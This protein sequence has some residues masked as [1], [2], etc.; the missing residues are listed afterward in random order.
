VQEC[1]TFLNL[2]AHAAKPRFTGITHVLDSG[3]TP[4]A[5]DS[6][7]VQAGHL[8]DIVKVGWG[9]GYVDPTMPER[10]R[11]YSKHGC[12]VSL[13]GTLLEVAALQDKVG[14]LRDWALS[15]GISHVEVSNGLCA[16]TD[17][18]KHA[19]VRELA[20]DFAVLAETGSKD[21]NYPPTPGEWADEM[22]RDLEA[23]A[24]WVVAEGR[25]SGTV[26]LYD[27]DHVVRDDLVKAILTWIPQDR[28]IFEA[29]VKSQQ[30][31]FIRQLGPDV[32]VGNVAPASVLP[33]ETLRLGLR[34]DTI[35]VDVLR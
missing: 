2:P 30:A 18:R 34:A 3:L 24:T 11:I 5:T 35:S 4:L 1:P 33:L 23:G 8:V 9:I 19:L 21:G 28:V 26:G 31:W 10:V 20:A 15:I 32:N 12:P 27:A 29:P 14:E 25:E 7:L 17:S 6:F 13:G 22:A 16:L